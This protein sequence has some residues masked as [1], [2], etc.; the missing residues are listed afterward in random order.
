M[1]N[2]TNYFAGNYECQFYA[3][4]FMSWETTLAPKDKYDPFTIHSDG[5][6]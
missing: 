5:Y 3:N 6:I 1:V 4:P 2:G